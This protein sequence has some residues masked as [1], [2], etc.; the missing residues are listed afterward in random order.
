M[1][2][3]RGQAAL[4]LVIITFIVIGVYISQIN[5]FRQTTMATR[6]GSRDDLI[7][8]EILETI[9]E[10]MRAARQT[11]QSGNCPTAPTLLGPT[12]AT[13]CIPSDNFIRCIKDPMNPSRDLCIGTTGGTTNTIDFVFHDTEEEAY[14][15]KNYFVFDF[16]PIPKVY[17]QNDPSLPTLSAPPVHTYNPETAAGMNIF[18]K[19]CATN[20]YCLTARVSFVKN[21]G[22]TGAR[23]YYQTFG[24]N[25]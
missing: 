19:N 23:V 7:A 14:E 20:L 22:A 4:I 11:A 18:R 15:E 17:A 5:S 8:G 6:I 13:Y 1:R 10:T 12:G 9:G 21:F 24:I 25:R 3:I 2:N 16:D